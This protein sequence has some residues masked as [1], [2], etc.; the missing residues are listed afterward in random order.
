MDIKRENFR[1]RIQDGRTL[2]IDEMETGHIFNS[3]KMI[4]NHLAEGHGGEPIWFQKKYINYKDWAM[5][6]T[7]ELAFTVCLFCWVIEERDDL[8]AKYHEPYMRIVNQINPKK[9][10]EEARE[11]L[12]V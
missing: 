6:E 8:P 2:T 10:L 12:P 1:W 3:M 9:F 11:C 5:T 4:F 7:R